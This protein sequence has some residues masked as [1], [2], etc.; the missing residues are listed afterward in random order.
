VRNVKWWGA[1]VC[2][3]YPRGTEMVE[4]I[5]NDSSWKSRTEVVKRVT[6]S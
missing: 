1:R 4:E 2:V 6:E 3:R 5:M